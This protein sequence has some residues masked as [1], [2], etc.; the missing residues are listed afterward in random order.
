MQ[1][2]FT[3]PAKVIH[4]FIQYIP[5]IIILNKHYSFCKV[6]NF[7]LL[8]RKKNNKAELSTFFTGLF[9]YESKKALQ[10]EIVKLFCLSVYIHAYLKVYIIIIKTYMQE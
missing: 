6:E 5:Y 3:N 8:V 2:F 9:T 10:S 4:G 1:D 7:T